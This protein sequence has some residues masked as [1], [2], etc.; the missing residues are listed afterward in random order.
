[1]VQKTTSYGKNA[2]TGVSSS[3]SNQRDRSRPRQMR[4]KQVAIT[5]QKLQKS[6]PALLYG[7]N[8][9][10]SVRKT[11]RSNQSLISSESKP[12]IISK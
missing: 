7:D 3:R 12:S 8:P 5:N 4:D 9:I 6:T 2:A 11:A 1:M 10:P